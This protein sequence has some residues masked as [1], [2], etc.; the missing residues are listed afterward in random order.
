MWD[1]E[2][3]LLDPFV[4]GGSTLS[5]KILDFEKTYFCS[6]K[7]YLYNQKMLKRPTNDNDK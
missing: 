4:G 7:I 3:T 1:R 2:G 6:A 5:F